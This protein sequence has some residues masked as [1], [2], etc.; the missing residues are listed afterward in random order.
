MDFKG[1]PKAKKRALLVQVLPNEKGSEIR[2]VPSLRNNH[3]N[4]QPKSFRSSNEVYTD[5]EDEQVNSIHPRPVNPTLQAAHHGHLHQSESR[6]L[7]PGESLRNLA[8][9]TLS[10]ENKKRKN[11]KRVTGV[12]TEAMAVAHIVHDEVRNYLKSQPMLPR[13][14]RVL[15]VQWY[16]AVRDQ[17]MDQNELLVENG[18]LATERRDLDK[19]IMQQRQGLVSLKS[20]IRGVESE[21]KDLEHRISVNQQ[22][23]R[24]QRDATRFLEGLGQLAA[25]SKSAQEND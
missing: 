16:R 18:R 20:H 11:R 9:S 22:Q 6:S 2:N 7:F 8:D 10:Y 19:Q 12:H 14:E 3:K 4:A 24:A 25:T 15:L 21:V 13:D 5:S 1:T 23:S 17:M